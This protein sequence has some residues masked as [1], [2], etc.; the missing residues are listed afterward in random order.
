MGSKLL[1]AEGEEKLGRFQTFQEI[2]DRQRLKMVRFD[3]LE[4]G[5]TNTNPT[6]TPSHCLLRALVLLGWPGRLPGLKC[7]KW[8]IYKGST[9][10]RSQTLRNPKHSQRRT[11]N[12]ARVKINIV[13]FCLIW[14]VSFL[15]RDLW[16]INE[17]KL[18]KV[19]PLL[20]KVL[21]RKPVHISFWC[22]TAAL[23]T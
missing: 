2:S 15:L 10:R 17:I 3:D 18:Y 11:W 21:Q 4:R 13:L 23:L 20:Y 14:T 6:P 22:Y 8:W 7:L 16:A 5:T 1:P 12:M 19:E 9:H